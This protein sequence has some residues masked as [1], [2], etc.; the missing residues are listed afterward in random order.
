MPDLTNEVSRPRPSSIRLFLAD[1]RADGLRLVEKSNWTGLALVCARADYSRVRRREEWSRP[2]V[3]ILTGAATAATLR[4]RLYV[5]EADDVRERVDS[6]VKAKDFWTGVIAFTSKDEN[7]NK[8][9]VRYLEARLLQLAKSADRATLDNGTNP[10]LPRLSEAD[11]ADMEGYL[12]EMLVILP[13]R[14]HGLRS[15]RYP[16]NSRRST[17]ALEARVPWPQGPTPRMV[18]WFSRDRLPVPQPFLRSTGT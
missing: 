15:A 2:G 1:G 5:G 17:P 11:R 7:L 12:D 6:H 16:G 4:Q 3:Y 14:G 8:G 13:P 9:H 10:P 18:S